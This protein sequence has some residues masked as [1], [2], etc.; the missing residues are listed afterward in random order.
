MRAWVDVFGKPHL[1]RLD[2]DETPFALYRRISHSHSHSFLFEALTEPGKMAETTLMGFGPS[3]IVRGY[4]DHLRII[5]SEGART[6]PSEDPLGALRGLMKTAQ[7]DS[8]RYVGG[9]VG[10]VNYDAVRLI[11]R[12][13][14]S[15]LVPEPLFEFGIYDDGIIMDAHT[16]EF[17]YFWYDT[18]RSGL[19]DA[20]DPGPAK[21]DI[22]EPQSEMD[23]ERF[24]D[25]V[26]KAQQYIYAGDIFQVVLSRRFT[27]G[28]SGDPLALYSRLRRLNPSPYMF[29][30]KQGSP[31]CHRCVPGNAG[32]DNRQPGRDLPHSG[33]AAHGRNPRGN[34]EAGRGDDS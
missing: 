18:D 7:Y 14:R 11:E 28:A 29:H 21:F 23:A 12:V 10:M 24:A 27:F 15:H 20:P 25:M 9:A 34:P 3:T 33:N 4:D 31:H 32:A 1:T 6:M 30:L 19:L 17:Q 16:G 8:H 26:Q 13:P 22:E 2:T 5:T